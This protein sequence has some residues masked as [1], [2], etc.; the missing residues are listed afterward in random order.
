MNNLE[1]QKTLEK[2]YENAQ[3]HFFKTVTEYLGEIKDKHVRLEMAES[4]HDDIEKNWESAKGTFQFLGSMAY[5]VGLDFCSQTYPNRTVIGNARERLEKFVL[6]EDFQKEFIEKFVNVIE[7]TDIKDFEAIYNRYSKEAEDEIP[8]KYIPTL[9]GIEYK[10][11]LILSNSSIAVKYAVDVKNIM[12][13]KSWTYQDIIKMNTTVSQYCKFM[14]KAAI[15]KFNALFMDKNY[16]DLL[17]TAADKFEQYKFGTLFIES[18]QTMKDLLIS[19]RFT[20]EDILRMLN[21]EI[22]EEEF[23]KAEAEFQEKLKSEEIKKEDK[24]PVYEET[25]EEMMHN[26][27]VNAVLVIADEAIDFNM[28][29]EEDFIKGIE[30]V[31]NAP[32]YMGSIYHYIKAKISSVDEKCS[33]GKYNVT[34]DKLIETVEKKVVE[35]RADYKAVAEEICEDLGDNK[36]E[37]NQLVNS[38]IGCLILESNDQKSYLISQYMQP[39]IETYQHL[40]QIMNLIEESD[41]I[42]NDEGLKTYGKLYKF[43]KETPAIADKLVS[44]NR[45]EPLFNKLSMFIAVKDLF[46]KYKESLPK[47]SE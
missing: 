16:Q 13:K 10:T 47:S 14:G 4:L 35:L 5:L 15:N 25:V 33:L 43:V 18:I 31:C 6:P 45:A 21:G 17:K 26:D 11:K 29:T 27:P 40:T 24:A 12:D 46:N 2:G 8:K 28:T 19:G 37:I 44:I 20:K 9:S 36:K 41:M 7:K 34:V 1:K 22:T 38:M 3:M 42:A 30:A 23:T 32:E 39:S